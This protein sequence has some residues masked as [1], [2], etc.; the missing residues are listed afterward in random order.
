MGCN[1]K[2]NHGFRLRLLT[3]YAVT[4]VIGALTAHGSHGPNVPGLIWRCAK[5]G[6]GPRP[7]WAQGQTRLS[8]VQAHLG[9]GPAGQMERLVQ[10]WLEK[11]K[12]K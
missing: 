5:Y 9:P 2:R 3:S 10:S 7:I 4:I 1:G 6:T 12:K 8:P 11:A